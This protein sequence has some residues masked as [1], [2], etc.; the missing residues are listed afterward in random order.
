MYT[1]LCQIEACLNSWPLYPMSDDPIDF[2][3]L[4][5]AHFLIG[6]SINSLQDPDIGHLSTNRLTLYQL[7]Q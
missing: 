3:V 5:P 6:T 4:T 7:I 2:I 1:V